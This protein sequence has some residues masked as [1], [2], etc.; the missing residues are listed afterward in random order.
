M[1]S[2]PQS[3]FNTTFCVRR[4]HDPELYSCHVQWNESL[5]RGEQMYS[6]SKTHGIVLI[7]D[8]VNFFVSFSL[9]N[10]IKRIQ[11]I[12]VTGHINKFTVQP[13][14]RWIDLSTLL[15]GLYQV[16]IYTDNNRMSHDKIIKL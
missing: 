13:N 6:T 16:I 11:L 1:Q 8:V 9:A 12:D 3:L 2:P 10:A 7:T 14:Q 5:A 4:F 15:P